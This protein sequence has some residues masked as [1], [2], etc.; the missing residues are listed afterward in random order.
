MSPP[1]TPNILLTGFEA[2][3]DDPSGAGLNPSALA[4]RA[5]GG[6]II[7]GHLVVAAVLPCVFGASTDALKKLIKTHRPALVVCVGQASERSAMSLERVAINLDDAPLP[8][9][10]GAQPQDTAIIAKGKAAYFS[11]LPVK[12]M[13]ADVHSAGLA[14]E[15]S[16]TAGSF[17]CNHVFYN[18][19]HL[20]ATR[21][22]MKHMRGGFIHVPYLPEQAAPSGAPSMPLDTMVHGL[23]V[24]VKSALRHL[25]SSNG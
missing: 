21:A 14:C 20:L 16:Y 23:R 10:A 9:N 3:G 25:H 12:K 11:T 17:V 18:L 13:L 19:M 2:F 6:Q 4:V 15:L 1:T 22:S 5:L 8:D 7:E 24:A